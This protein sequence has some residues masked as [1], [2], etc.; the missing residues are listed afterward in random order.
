MRVH[1]SGSDCDVPVEH[2][3]RP[4][5]ARAVGRAEEPGT[6]PPRGFVP[7]HQQADFQMRALLRVREVA[8]MLAV[9]R[10]V[11]YEMCRSG[12]LRVLT[13]G[14]A[15]RVPVASVH[16]WIE[17]KLAEQGEER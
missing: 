15:I 6:T 7:Q 11:A 14:R 16:A 8:A 13:R 2:G 12:E 5:H 1:G 17:Q 9:P 4:P 3:H 10:S